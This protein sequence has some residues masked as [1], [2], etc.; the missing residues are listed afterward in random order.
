M[1][2]YFL[3]HSFIRPFQGQNACWHR[4]K[5][6]GLSLQSCAT[7]LS[8]CQVP[9]NGL[10]VVKRNLSANPSSCQK[11]L[12][13][14]R[15]N[16]D[17][18]IISIFEESGFYYTLGPAYNEHFDAKE[19]THCKRVLVVTKLAVTGILLIVQSSYQ[20]FIL[21]YLMSTNH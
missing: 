4:L 2:K 19:F 20:C 15:C 13:M 8:S 9:D 7:T 3:E 5:I 21:S 14:F 11:V 12:P 6:D 10:T 16:K 1:Q 17:T 18:A